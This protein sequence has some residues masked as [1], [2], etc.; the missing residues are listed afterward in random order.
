VGEGDPCPC[1]PSA[2]SFTLVLSAYNVLTGFY[3]NG[4]S[5]N[6]VFRGNIP[7]NLVTLDS[8]VAIDIKPGSD[9]NII[10]LK[11]RGVVPVAVLTNDD[12]DA[13][14]IDPDTVK[15]AGAEPV[16]WKLADVDDDGDI[17]MMFHFR[18]QQ[19][20][21]DQSSTEAILTAQLTGLMRTQSTEEASGGTTVSGTDKVRIISSKK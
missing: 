3:G 10:N 14:T 9:E 5:I 4:E 12:F 21:L 17:D 18:T 8:G 7:I 15:F 11:S 20:E 19:L 13:A 2:T 1:E 16:H 6:L